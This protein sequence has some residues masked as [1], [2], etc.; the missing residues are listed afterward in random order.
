MSS[1][2]L[3]R[4][5]G[6]SPGAVLLRLIVLSFVVGFILSAIN[7]HPLE[8]FDWVLDFF[9]RI[10]EMGFEAIDWAIQYFLLGAVVVVP[11]WL[12]MRVT[13]FGQRN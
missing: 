5:I 11:I 12:I 13:R 6:G 7:I 3:H 10:Y 2:A 1:S 9:K 8:I 4:F